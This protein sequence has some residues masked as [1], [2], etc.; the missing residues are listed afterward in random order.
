MYSSDS[1][2]ND[3]SQVLDHTTEILFLL[4]CSHSMTSLDRPETYNVQQ[5]LQ[6]QSHTRG[7][8]SPHRRSLSLKG[9]STST[10]LGCTEKFITRQKLGDF[11]TNTRDATL[12]GAQTS[13]MPGDERDTTDHPIVVISKVLICI[14]REAPSL[15][16]QY[17]W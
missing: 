2:D 12:A 14:A 3:N 6:G 8:T 17:F 5:Q 1:H 11:E 10:E 16:I 15:D 4:V 7:P 9:P 13:T